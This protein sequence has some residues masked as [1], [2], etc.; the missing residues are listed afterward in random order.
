MRRM[1]W[2]ASSEAGEDALTELR[3]ILDETLDRVRT[4]IF[5]AATTPP[6]GDRPDSPGERPDSPGE[7]SHAPRA[8]EGNGEHP[9]EPPAETNSTGT[10]GDSTP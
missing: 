8:G 1:A 10:A 5:G 7:L 9:A 4:E 2:Q 3:I 6:S